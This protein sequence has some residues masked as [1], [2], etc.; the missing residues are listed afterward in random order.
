MVAEQLSVINGK[1]VDIDLVVAVKKFW[2][3]LIDLDIKKKLF[4]MRY[5]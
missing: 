1:Y 5:P 2:Y 3:Q 4:Y